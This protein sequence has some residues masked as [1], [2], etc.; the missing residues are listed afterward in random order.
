MLRII[1]TGTEKEQRWTLYGQLTGPWVA[2]LKANWENT[3]ADSHGRSCV[4]DL[5]DVTF[6]DEC[7]EY[8][9]R[10]MQNEGAKFV[11]RGVE[12][13]QLL[14]DLTSKRKP[15]LR[16]CLEHLGHKPHF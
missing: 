5:T 3:H 4:V 15:S 12:T 9:L 13:K 10:A 2:E 6:I 8:V 16:K 1:N 14:A 7:G 11:A